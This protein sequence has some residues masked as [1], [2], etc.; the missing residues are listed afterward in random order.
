MPLVLDNILRITGLNKAF[1][2]F[3]LGEKYFNVVIDLL[4]L[5]FDYNCSQ[6]VNYNWQ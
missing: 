3:S 5:N 2:H 6:Y 1:F 4:I